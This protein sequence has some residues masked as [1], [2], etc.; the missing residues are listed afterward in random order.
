[1]QVWNAVTGQEVLINAS[2]GAIVQSLVWSPDSKHIASA[3]EGGYVEVWD[4]ATGRGLY[5]YHVDFGGIQDLSWSPD[6]R[7]L[8]ATTQDNVLELLNG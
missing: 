1:M 7:W 6:D 3:D 8:A 5:T 4:A 2:H